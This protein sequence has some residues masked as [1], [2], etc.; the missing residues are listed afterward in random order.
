MST[1]QAGNS[2][3]KNVFSGLTKLE[4]LYLKSNLFNISIQNELI[5]VFSLIN[6]TKNCTIYLWDNFRMKSE[7][8]D[9][10]VNC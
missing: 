5:E 9:P 10:T 2:S 8:H 6:N 3:D 7:F 4:K 1:H